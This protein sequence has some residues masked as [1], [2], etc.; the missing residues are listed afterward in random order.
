MTTKTC[1]TKP[2]TRFGQTT[3]SSTFMTTRVYPLVGVNGKYVVGRL[4]LR[5]LERWD[6]GP[7]ANH[8]LAPVAA[9]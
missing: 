5:F 8:S 6:V 7:S 3:F 4:K 2:T 1:L 9:Q